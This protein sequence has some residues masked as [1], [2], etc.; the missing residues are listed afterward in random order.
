MDLKI[1]LGRRIRECRVN[2]GLTQT[3]LA[4]MIC[5]DSKHVSYLELGKSMP[6]PKLIIKFAEIFELEIKDLFD[7]Y[8]LQNKPELK[9]Y[10]ITQINALETEQLE[11]IC[12]YV[13][14]FVM[15]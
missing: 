2:K 12:K 3:E 4:E 1:L 6:N 5:I 13:R 8:H 7:F 11:N 14:T 15:K 9:E 10:L